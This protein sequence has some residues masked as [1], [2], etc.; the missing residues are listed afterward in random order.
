MDKEDNKVKIKTKPK[1]Y[2][3]R[4]SNDET[5]FSG[6]KLKQYPKEEKWYRELQQ[7]LNNFQKATAS[8]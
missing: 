4:A 1:T 3:F 7:K 5:V 6:I 2:N 8:S